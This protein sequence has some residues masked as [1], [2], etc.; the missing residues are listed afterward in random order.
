[1]NKI[2][3]LRC[4]IRGKSNDSIKLSPLKIQANVKR[5]L[6]HADEL[7]CKLDYTNTCKRGGQHM[8]GK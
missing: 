6:T 2:R 7:I 3:V 4:V 1:M 8:A 5:I